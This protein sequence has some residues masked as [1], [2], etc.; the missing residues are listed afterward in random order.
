MQQR[1]MRFLAMLV[2]LLSVGSCAS[3]VLGRAGVASDGKIE[4]DEVCALSA[5]QEWRGQRLK[6]VR[7]PARVE[8]R[9]EGDAKEIRFAPMPADSG[10]VL[11]D[12]SSETRW[13]IEEL[14]V[15]AGTEPKGAD[16]GWAGRSHNGDIMTCV[17]RVPQMAV[18]ASD[19]KLSSFC[20]L[21]LVAM[22][23]VD[24]ESLATGGL[25]ALLKSGAAMV[26]VDM[27]FPEAE[28]R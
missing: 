1:K 7:V 15:P 21:R 14:L 28:G 16:E 24:V 22:T 9:K 25:E 8:V 6:L 26:L 4:Q 12:A 10:Y 27:C 5:E 17:F 2:I 13:L 18:V 19:N 23:S 3:S 11:I 20:R